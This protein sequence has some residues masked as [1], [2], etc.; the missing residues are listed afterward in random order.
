MKIEIELPKGFMNTAVAEDNHLTAN[1]N[2]SAN[3]KE[4][5]VKLPTGKWVIFSVKHDLVTLLKIE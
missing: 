2:D 4:L 3:W 5:R 1:T